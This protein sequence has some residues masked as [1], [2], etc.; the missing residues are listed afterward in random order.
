MAVTAEIRTKITA[1]QWH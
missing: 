1:A